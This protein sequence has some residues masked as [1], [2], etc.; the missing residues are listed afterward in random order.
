MAGSTKLFQ[1]AGSPLIQ[2]RS[3]HDRTFLLD[4]V[5]A[6][7]ASVAALFILLASSVLLDPTLPG[8]EVSPAAILVLIGLP[9]PGI[10][11]AL[12]TCALAV[13]VGRGLG[14]RRAWI[15]GAI[16]GTIVGVFVMVYAWR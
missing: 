13:W 5:L 8:Y 10:A 6:C 16:L 11:A 3:R 12:P 7:I 4:W 15:G 14:W 1:R 2:G 9:L